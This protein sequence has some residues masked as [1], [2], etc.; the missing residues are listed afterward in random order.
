M[1]ALTNRIRMTAADKMADQVRQW[2]E[3]VQNAILQG[4][5]SGRLA[6]LEAKLDEHFSAEPDW[7]EEELEYMRTRVA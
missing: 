6:E 1:A 2:A 3:E 5:W 4:R 7:D